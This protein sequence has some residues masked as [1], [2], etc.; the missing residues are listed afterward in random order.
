M[1]KNLSLLCDFYEFTM[2]NGYL[3]SGLAEKICYFEVYFR[4]APDN[5]SF[6]ITAGLERILQFI[7]DLHFDEEDIEFF[8]KKGIFSEEFLEFLANF[9]F[10][11]DVWA[12][13]EGEVAFAH[14]PILIIKAPAAQAQLLETFLLLTLN[15]QSLIA[16]KASRV[17]RAARGR[18][19]LEFGSRRAQ[20]TDAAL[21]GARAAF[22]GGVDATACALADKL[23]GIEASGTMAHSWVQMFE[24]ELEAFLRY[25]EIYPQNAVLLVDTYDAKKGIANA[26]KAFKQ[27]LV[28]RGITKCGIRIDSGDL[29]ELLH[30]AR[31]ELDNAGLGEC[32]IVVSGALDEFKIDELSGAKIDAFGVGERLITSQSSPVLGCVY[33]LCAI[34]EGDKIV[35][36]MKVSE[37]PYKISNP[38]LKRLYRVFDANG[39]ACFDALCLASEEL[40]EAVSSDELSEFC[41][42]FKAEFAQ[43]KEARFVAKELLFKVVEN[44]RLIYALPTAAQIRDYAKSRLETLSFEHKSL[45]TPKNYN[46]LL[47][48]RLSELKMRMLNEA[49]SEQLI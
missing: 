43:I 46:L 14:E 44:G 26:I 18:A 32:K 25:C 7:C 45:Y 4:R 6:V 27:T 8:R 3:K 1:K 17:V 37:S 11:G 23:W 40:G 42:G 22:I 9:K 13:R 21:S 39:A 30:Y 48:K 36:K 38:H 29:Q 35:P 34:Q 28:P 12:M 15:H 33:K 5:S 31:T 47:S 19:V 20:G 2:A 16:T 10:S 24:S 49:K 41:E